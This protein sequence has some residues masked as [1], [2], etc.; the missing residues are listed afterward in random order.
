MNPQLS[1]DQ[2]AAAQHQSG[3]GSNPDPVERFLTRA[4]LVSKLL[5]CKKSFLMFEDY[6][7][8]G[9]VL[10]LICLVLF[11]F[12]QI[13]TKNGRTTVLQSKNLRGLGNGL[14]R[15]LHL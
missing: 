9:I 15:F 1:T 12:F 11:R 7:R 3:P 14:V 6:L 4:R 10:H 2:F 13:N 5:K 8:Q